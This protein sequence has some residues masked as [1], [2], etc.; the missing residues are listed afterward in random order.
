M[1]P[2]KSPLGWV[3][4]WIGCWPEGWRI[5]A[6][7]KPAT[8][9]DAPKEATMNPRPPSVPQHPDFGSVM[10]DSHDR[11]KPFTIRIF[12]EAIFDFGRFR[13]VAGSVTFDGRPF[14]IKVWTPQSRSEIAAYTK[15]A[16]DLAGTAALWLVNGRVDPAVQEGD[17]RE[18]YQPVSA[19][20]EAQ[21]PAD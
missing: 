10:W 17:R 14:S 4:C 1:T 3:V 2:T 11:N 15:E 20:M 8:P 16:G 5:A 18:R 19:R 6:A 13:E 9:S 21:K 7:E 12:V